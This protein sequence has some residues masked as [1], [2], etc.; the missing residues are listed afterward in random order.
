MWA[1]NGIDGWHPTTRASLRAKGVWRSVSCQR[2]NT[3]NNTIKMPP[4]A[5]VLVDTNAVQVITDWIKSLP[6]TPALTPP[7]LSPNCGF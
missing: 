5:R 4:L 2:M 7:T 6:G 3:M 1:A